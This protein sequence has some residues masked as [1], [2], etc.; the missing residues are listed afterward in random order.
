[1]AVTAEPISAWQ[2]TGW[3]KPSQR[4]RALMYPVPATSFAGMRAPRWLI[5]L[6]LRSMVRPPGNGIAILN[7]GA[8]ISIS[9]DGSVLNLGASGIDSSSASQDLTLNSVVHLNSSQTWS[10]SAGHLISDTNIISGSANLAK[11][12]LGTLILSGN[13]TYSGN[14]TISSGKLQLG[15]GS[16]S[17]SVSGAII[18]NGTLVLNRSDTV[19]VANLINGSGGFTQ[20]GSGTVRIV[21][22]PTASPARWQSRLERCNSPEREQLMRAR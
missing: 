9:D 2:G 10:T 12:G 20:A 8:A 5:R 17:G 6:R 22:P 11:T 3:M 14:T 18:D 21:V 15:N 1:M 4:I 13:N 16:N 7:P 19:N